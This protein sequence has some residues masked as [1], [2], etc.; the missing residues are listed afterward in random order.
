MMNNIPKDS[1]PFPFPSSPSL[2]SL[3]LGN[4]RYKSPSLR[5]S[6]TNSTR[7]SKIS[8][9]SPKMKEEDFYKG[10]GELMNNLVEHNTY[11]KRELNLQERVI[12][13]EEE[14][15][16]MNKLLGRRKNEE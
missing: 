3:S 14:E 6:V 8:Q 16:E 1:N 5:S 15:F 12:E 7:T 2:P 4:T 9:P 10:R 11:L 13:K